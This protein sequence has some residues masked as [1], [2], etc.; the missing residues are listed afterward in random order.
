MQNPT[1]L[2]NERLAIAREQGRREASHTGW[3][4]IT[5]PSPTGGR[6]DLTVLVVQGRVAAGTDPLTNWPAVGALWTA[7][8]ED[9]QARGLI[10]AP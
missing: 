3:H 2:Q 5:G 10:S 1:E 4:S 6:W 8:L 9:I 7:V